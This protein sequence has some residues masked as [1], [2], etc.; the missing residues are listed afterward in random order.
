MGNRQLQPHCN[1]CWP[2]GIEPLGM[3]AIR[4]T[5][6]EASERES[7]LQL[8]VDLMKDQRKLS[9]TGAIMHAASEVIGSYLGAS[10]SGFYQVGRHHTLEFAHGWTNGHFPAPKGLFPEMALGTNWAELA[11]SGTAL[12]ISDVSTNLLTLDSVLPTFGVHAA[13]LVSLVRR[14]VWQGG[15]YVNQCEERAW[16]E[17]EIS[18]A[19]EVAEITL[20]ALERTAA[21]H[22]LYRS[23]ARAQRIFESIGDGVI[24][25][26]TESNI[27]LMNPVAQQLTGW[28]E[29]RALGLP[30]QRVFRI[31]HELTRF[32]V[33]S[34]VDKV[35]RLGTVV[36]FAGHTVLVQQDGREVPID[37]S[38]APIREP[39]GSLS[40]I[41]L[42]FRDISVRRRLEQ[43]REA[44]LREIRGRYAELE[45]I[46]NNAAVA[47]ALID[48]TEFRYLRVNQKLCEML[49][50]TRAAI[51]GSK[52]SDVAA[53]FVGLQEAL[54]SV[55]NGQ[56]VTGGVMEG[57]ASNMPGVR[58]YWTMDF[59]PVRG[60]DGSV[61]AIAA[62][63]AEITGQKQAEAALMQTEKLAAVGRLASSIAHE[64]N[65]P[66]ESVT[67]L[68]FLI[69]THELPEQ[70]R[71]YVTMAERELRRVSQITSQ[72]LRFHKQSTKPSQVSC[73]QLIEEVL[74]I[75]QGRLCNSGIS[76]EKRMRA[77]QPVHCFE[78]EIRQVIN[79]LVGNAIDA[80]RPGGRLV[81]R[82][83][84]I[85]DQ[86][87]MITVADTGSGM[88]AQTAQK[89]F[90]PFFT[91]KGYSGTGLGL[92]ISKEI[93]TRHQG[94]LGLRSCQQ[95]GRSGTVINAYLP[96]AGASR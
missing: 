33:E 20:D 54:H 29:Q 73:N 61:V 3:G 39:D 8:L 69:S 5:R 19:A 41:V 15:L 94:K 28:D 93:M 52:V 81:L 22:D 24:V 2:K 13:I 86:G 9:G 7:Q 30:L 14:G 62:A 72:T 11:R 53:N 43:H 4:V 34:P 58:R 87:V 91:T 49:G 60:A 10:Q 90:E 36:G 75:H 17:E 67:N 46:Y 74:A 63:S 42:I 16:K 56:S 38:A 31:I 92:W 59:A 89:I 25:T 27:T 26:D 77:Q 95:P 79:N 65:N 76:V 70:V 35:K 12:G 47:M 68:L 66:L 37:D 80:M 82:T 55:T 88:S 50:Q 18:L 32:E 44:L 45:A 57:E 48:T 64:I 71:Q 96:F 23:E 85:T 40:G 51:V 84:A 78:G 1:T 6:F 21:R 83:R